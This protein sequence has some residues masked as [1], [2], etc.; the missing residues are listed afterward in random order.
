MML[1]AELT[2]PTALDQLRTARM[3]A[4]RI[5]RDRGVGDETVEDI[6]LAVGE[7]CV[8][9]FANVGQLELTFLADGHD[10]VVQVRPI[11]TNAQINTPPQA[12]AT[13]LSRVI[14]QALVPDLLEID[15]SLTMR[16]PG[17]S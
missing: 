11:G 3:L 12:D 15:G 17:V 1:L 2:I 7:A 5:A 4:A 14:L 8:V 16:W 13:D 10:F 6:K 9:Q